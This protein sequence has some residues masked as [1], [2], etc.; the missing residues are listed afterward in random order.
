MVVAQRGQ[1]LPEPPHRVAPNPRTGL[2]AGPQPAPPAEP[3]AS[4][5]NELPLS[6]RRQVRRAV[7]GAKGIRVRPRH[8]NTWH[9]DDGTV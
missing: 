2:L 9:E 4:E 6:P 3:E 5:P 1:K 8:R 7:L